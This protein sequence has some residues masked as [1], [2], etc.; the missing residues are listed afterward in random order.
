[1][2]LPDFLGRQL[3]THAIGLRCSLTATPIR[4]KPPKR[5]QYTSLQRVPRQHHV[6]TLTSYL[7]TA[8]FFADLHHGGFCLG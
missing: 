1:M 6:S 3:A 4:S 2:M 7:S 8:S 5:I